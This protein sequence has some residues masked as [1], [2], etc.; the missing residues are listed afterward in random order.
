MV[1]DNIIDLDAERREREPPE[2]PYMRAEFRANAPVRMVGVPRDAAAMRAA[3]YD[4][5]NA[6]MALLTES[7]RLEPDGNHL[8]RMVAML[9]HSARVRVATYNGTGPNDAESAASLDWMARCVPYIGQV[10]THL[11]EQARNDEGNT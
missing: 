4:M 8:P 11:R 1:D 9:F 7:C 2:P 3:A 5:V 10:L 6:A